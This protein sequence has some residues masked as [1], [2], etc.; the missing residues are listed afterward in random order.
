[1]V[2]VGGGGEVMISNHNLPYSSSVSP[3]SGS[4]SYM[5]INAKE[6]GGGGD[7]LH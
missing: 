7:N 5:Y 4:C 6:G 2:V 1:M 3:P